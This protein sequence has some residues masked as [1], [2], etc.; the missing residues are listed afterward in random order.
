MLH[1][2]SLLARVSGKKL[3]KHFVGNSV[4]PIFKAIGSCLLAIMLPLVAY[5][6]EHVFDLMA[7]VKFS[8][9]CFSLACGLSM[10]VLTSREYIVGA[11]GCIIT[12]Y[13]EERSM[14]LAFSKIF[15]SQKS[16]P[17]ETFQIR[18]LCR[19]NILLQALSH[20]V[21]RIRILLAFTLSVLYLLSINLESG[22]G[23]FS[24]NRDIFVVWWVN[25][26]LSDH[27]DNFEAQV[28]SDALLS[29]LSGTNFAYGFCAGSRFLVGLNYV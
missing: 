19:E 10:I 25:P 4:E 8:F 12:A 22:L 9:V 20:C 2:F 15:R 13:A 23:S 26:A 11:I 21:F 14:F 16:T 24:R 29:F 6:A 1:N 5:L 3:D 17:L 7:F 27:L 28:W 18:S